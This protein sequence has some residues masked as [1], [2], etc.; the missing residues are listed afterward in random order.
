ML[1]DI[2]MYKYFFRDSTG[3]TS[4][5]LDLHNHQVKSVTSRKRSS[6]QWTLSL[7]PEIV[8]TTSKLVHIDILLF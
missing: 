2:N 1:L 5:E 3:Y 8:L 6:I 7:M 4:S